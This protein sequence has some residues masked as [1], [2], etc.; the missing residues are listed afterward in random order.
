M[1]KSEPVLLADQMQFD[2]GENVAL[3]DESMDEL[4]SLVSSAHVP[5]P[6]RSAGIGEAQELGASHWLDQAAEGAVTHEWE[7]D[8]GK[9][10]P[11]MIPKRVP[12][13]SSSLADVLGRDSSVC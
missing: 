7:K 5:A 11:S 2:P 12:M 3:A 8:E 13:R 10:S 9:V 1:R 4:L 6:K